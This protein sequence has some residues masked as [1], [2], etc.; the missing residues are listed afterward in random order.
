MFLS[1]VVTI[2]LLD[3]LICVLVEFREKKADRQPFRCPEKS[4]DALFLFFFKKFIIVYSTRTRTLYLPLYVNL[5]CKS[6]QK[7]LTLASYIY[8]IF[9]YYEDKETIKK[10]IINYSK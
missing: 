6:N 3:E 5:K 4:A 1:C 2:C 7:R 8:L 10:R 9:S